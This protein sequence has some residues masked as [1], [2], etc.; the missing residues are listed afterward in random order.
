MK[1]CIVVCA[2]SL[3]CFAVPGWA[4]RAETPRYTAQQVFDKMVGADKRREVLMA[5]ITRSERTKIGGSKGKSKT[6]SG[7]LVVRKGGYARL[8]IIKPASQK[9]MTNGKVL[10]MELSE[11]EQVYRLSTAQMKNSGNFFLDLGGTIRFYAKNGLKRLIP[12]GGNFDTTQVVALELLPEDAEKSGFDTMRVW[13]DTGRWV[14]LRA[15]LKSK[16]ADVGVS[17]DKIRTFGTKGAKK[18]GYSLKL[19]KRY[20]RYSAPKNFEIFDLDF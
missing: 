16:T 18:N 9:L 15:M 19:D 17:F 6:V 4:K 11:V 14:I 2:L 20:F 5:N 1:F 12:P 13:V 3:G 8:N 10:W 7:T